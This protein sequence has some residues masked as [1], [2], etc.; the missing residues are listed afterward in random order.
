MWDERNGLSFETAAGG[1]EPP[2]PRLT[3]RRSTDRPPDKT[4]KSTSV[5]SRENMRK[6][7]TAVHQSGAIYIALI[8]LISLCVIFVIS[9]N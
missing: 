1:I 8:V 9:I 6:H 7:D 2:S 3:V 5:N 4:Q